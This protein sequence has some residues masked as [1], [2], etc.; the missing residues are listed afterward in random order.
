MSCSSAIGICCKGLPVEPRPSVG[1]TR[2]VQGKQTGHR[3]VA[4]L[5]E[6]LLDELKIGPVRRAAPTL[7]GLG[8]PAVTWTRGTQ[9]LQ[10][11][12]RATR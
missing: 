7:H 8:I 1:H 12:A 3:K 11:H 9:G 10:I 5:F 2:G 4:C 6:Q